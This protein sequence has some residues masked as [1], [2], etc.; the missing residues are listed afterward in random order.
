MLNLKDDNIKDL[1]ITMKVTKDKLNKVFDEI[2]ALKSRN[3]IEEKEN[4]QKIKDQ[5]KKLDEAKEVFLKVSESNNKS[6]ENMIKN[7]EVKKKKSEH[8]DKQLKV[9][10]EL[11]ADNER[12]MCLKQHKVEEL[13]NLINQIAKT[14]TTKSYG[15]IYEFL[16]IDD[17]MINFQI[18]NNSKCESLDELSS[19]VVKMRK[20]LAKSSK[21]SLMMKHSLLKGSMMDRKRIKSREKKLGLAQNGICC[22]NSDCNIF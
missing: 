10:K 11:A 14:K 12:Q 16:E 22:G 21:K 3:L 9:K 4:I 5:Q 7:L 13:E 19:F 18:E 8:F 6:K 1:E 2:Q 15:D 17:D 20:S